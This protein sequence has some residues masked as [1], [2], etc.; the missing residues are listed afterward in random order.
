MLNL[1]E[2]V[3]GHDPEESA[4]SASRQQVMEQKLSDEKYEGYKA[5]HSFSDKA[6]FLNRAHE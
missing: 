2:E 4:D 5:A 6:G 3:I 1:A